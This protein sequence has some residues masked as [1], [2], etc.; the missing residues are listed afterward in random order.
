MGMLTLL[1][2]M[3]MVEVTTMVREMIVRAMRMM[4]MAVM[5]Q[6]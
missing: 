1:L 5:A 4:R 2:S 6:R 3:L